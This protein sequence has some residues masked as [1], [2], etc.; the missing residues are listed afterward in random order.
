MQSFALYFC[1]SYEY[2]IH[3]QSE[4]FLC[5]L[6]G[7]RS[8]RLLDLEWF[9]CQSLLKTCLFGVHSQST[10]NHVHSNI[11]VQIAMLD[12]GTSTIPQP[13]TSQAAHFWSRS[14]FFPILT[15]LNSFICN[16]NN[17]KHQAN[18]NIYPQTHEP[19]EFGDNQ[20]MKKKK[21]QSGKWP[22]LCCVG[23]SCEGVDSNRW[24]LLQCKLCTN[25][26]DEYFGKSDTFSDANV[27]T[28]LR[29]H[30]LFIFDFQ[31]ILCTYVV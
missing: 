5:S 1:K 18:M 16:Q 28:A 7:H 25:I 13:L 8:S 2:H 15:P 27:K 11:S 24:L 21:N 17:Q 26:H 14:D 10:P 22:C 3:Y 12:L 19:C 31:A 20:N 29:S 23:S 6:S 4:K 9:T 30:R